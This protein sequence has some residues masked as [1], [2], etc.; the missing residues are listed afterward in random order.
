MI[1]GGCMQSVPWL[2][3]ALLATSGVAAARALVRAAPVRRAYQRYL[4]VLEIE[5]RYQGA[6]WNGRTVARAQLASGAACGA[7]ALATGWLSP[8]FA[9]GVIAFAPRSWLARLRRK[10]TTAIEQQLDTWLIALSHALRASPALGDGLESSVE[11][12]AS[13]L[14]DELRLLLRE[15]ALGSPLRRALDDMAQ[16][17]Q[18]PVVSVALST[19][20]I[21]NGTGG[22]FVHTLETSAAALREMARLEGVVRTKTAEGRAQVVVIGVI[23]VPML[24]TIHAMAPGMLTPLWT[25]DLGHVV[26]AIAGALWVAALLAARR[27]VHVDI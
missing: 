15:H 8:L 23:P 5:L 4:A 7:L 18:S 10:R 2:L 6:G 21:A 27:I 16:R 22:D 24:W 26:L 17:I 25:T 11:V 13:P 3:S 19:L 9:A 14:A 20:Q 1:G 12:V